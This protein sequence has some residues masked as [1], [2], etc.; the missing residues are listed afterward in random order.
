M[1]RQQQYGHNE[2]GGSIQTVIGVA[3]YE[4]QALRQLCV[5]IRTVASISVN[6]LVLWVH[7]SK[8]YI[9]GKPTLPVGSVCD[10]TQSLIPCLYDDHTLLI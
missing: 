9:L 8:V 10:C 2:K 1:Q 7:N 5:H 6:W 4:Y 3:S